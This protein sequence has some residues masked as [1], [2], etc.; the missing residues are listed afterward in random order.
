[1][2]VDEA[3]AE[4]GIDAPRLRGQARVGRALRT[5]ANWSQLVRFATVGASGY[6]INL[7][8]FAAA[9]HGA[10]ST[11]GSPPRRRSSSR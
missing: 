8:V 5:R 10:G 7:A 6:V 9:V 11:R 2:S 4:P 1:M 3:V